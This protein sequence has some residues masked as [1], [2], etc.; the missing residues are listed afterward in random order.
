MNL[1]LKIL[2]ELRELTFYPQQILNTYW[3]FLPNK[4][5]ISPSEVVNTNLNSRS[6]INS[7]IKNLL[8][9]FIFLSIPDQLCCTSSPFQRKCFVCDLLHRYGFGI[10][11]V[12]SHVTI[13]SMNKRGAGQGVETGQGLCIASISASY[14]F[15]KFLWGK[16][17]NTINLPRRQL[18]LNWVVGEPIH[19]LLGH[20]SG[21]SIILLSS[22]SPSSPN[23][24]PRLAWPCLVNWVRRL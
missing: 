20:G 3:R 19:V 11:V 9:L 24:Q 17:A 13:Y 4:I 15:W 7:C 22:S 8:R 21:E 18:N 14:C 23:D 16:A 1:Y 12:A 10:F 2:F 6:T 5:D